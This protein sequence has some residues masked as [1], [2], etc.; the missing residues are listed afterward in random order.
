M[1]ESLV[2]RSAAD[3]RGLVASRQ[4]SARDVLAATLARIDAVN[5]TLNAIVTLNTRVEDEARA[6]DEAIARGETPGPL[7]GVPVGI[8]DVTPVAGVRTTYGSPI[9]AD[10]VPTEDAV[11]VRRLREAGALIVGK[12]NCPEFAA[13][14]NTFNPVFGRTRNP[15]DPSKTC[16]GSTGGGAAALAS[17]MIALAEGTDLG[18]SLRIPASFSGVAGLRP[19]VGLVPTHPTGWH[20]DTLQVSGPMARSVADVALMLQAIAGA[21]AEAPFGSS[22]GAR[23]FTGAVAAG[24][25]PGLRVAYAPDPAGIGVDADVAAVCRAAADTLV[26]A[27]ATVSEVPLDLAFVRPAFLALRGLW[28]VT[29]LRHLLDQREHFGPNVSA[30]VAAGLATTVEQLADAERVRGRLWDLCRDLFTRVDCVV[31][32]CMAVPPFPVEQN[33]PDTVAGKP[34]ATYVDWIAPTFVWSMTGLPVAAVPAGLD[35][36]GLPAGLQ[37]VVPPG[38]EE[39]AL[40][41]AAAIEQRRPLGRPSSVTP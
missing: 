32:P 8:K 2:D 11:V 5:P 22:V 21:A 24:V 41:V 34:M 20:W 3:I 6:I 39:L 23:D 38:R 13:G 33:Y 10:H 7:C 36:R 37:V 14:G 31:T 29:H 12:T 4:L 30:N 9:Y 19:S 1:P 18:G 25:P 17:G 27:G 28:F 16:G 26:D 15:W 40:A 35:R